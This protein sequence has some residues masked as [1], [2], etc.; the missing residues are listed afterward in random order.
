MFR[1]EWRLER[2]D[3][4]L[5]RIAIVDENP[6]GQFL[7]PEFALFREMFEQHG[8]AAVVAD[9]G[10]FT[11]D[12]QR[13]MHDGQPVDLI[14][15]RLTDF[16]LDATVNGKIAGNFRKWRCRADAASAR[17]RVVCRQAQPDAAF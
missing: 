10:D 9:P 15:N 3:V 16:S 6:A 13:L 7:A 17:P 12:G 8:I 11:S 14:Y 5:R 2:G 4:P 1:E